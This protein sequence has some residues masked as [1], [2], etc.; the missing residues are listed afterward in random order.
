M[1]WLDLG[2]LRG[3]CYAGPMPPR[4]I[5]SQS[6]RQQRQEEKAAV[7]KLEKQ[8]RREVLRAG[9]VLLADSPV[10]WPIFECLVSEQWRETHN[11][12]QILVTR[13]H[14]NGK[15]GAAAFIVDLACLGVKSA[16]S[17]R[18]ADI[19]GYDNVIRSR[20]TAADTLVPCSPDLAL[21]II[22]AGVAYAYNLGFKPDKDS[23]AAIEYLHDANPDNIDEEIPTGGKDGR[24]YFISGPYDN[25]ERIIKTLD[26]SVG[27]GN[28]EF[29]IRMEEDDIG[30]LN[31]RYL[32]D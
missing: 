27:K 32:P 24:P 12:C 11:L 1:P 13:Q 30:S 8:A 25:V 20:M 28:Y 3:F 17:H 2:K 31:L 21:K 15:V 10:N 6:Q 14:E 9:G 5:P 29:I 22:Q 18:F 4:Q 7:R 23:K 19:D 16:M 26:E